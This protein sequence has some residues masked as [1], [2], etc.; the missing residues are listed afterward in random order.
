MEINVIQQSY[1]SDRCV[2]QYLNSCGVWVQS[3]QVHMNSIVHHKH[4]LAA[5]QQTPCMARVAMLFLKVATSLEQI[6]KWIEA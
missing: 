3:L 4:L 5:H 1:V 6:D 2:V